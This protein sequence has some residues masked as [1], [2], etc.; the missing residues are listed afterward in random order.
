MAKISTVHF[1]YSWLNIRP[2]QKPCHSLNEFRCGESERAENGWKNESSPKNGTQNRDNIHLFHI[3]NI[4]FMGEQMESSICSINICRFPHYNGISLC[5][6]PI[7]SSWSVKIDFDTDSKWFG[8][9]WHLPV[10]IYQEPMLRMCFC[11]CTRAIHWD[12]RISTIT[13]SECGQLN[14]PR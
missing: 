1:M 10:I 3:C 6:S 13:R 2:R 8:F 12:K 11:E 7:L 5:L 4:T 14:F 9:A